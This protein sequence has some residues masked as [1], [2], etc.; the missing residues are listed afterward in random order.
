[1]TDSQILLDAVNLSKRYRASAGVEAVTV[2]RGVSLRLRA[3]ESAAIVGPSGSGKS[4]LLNI[5][6]GLDRP[7]DGKVLIDG[8]DLSQQDDGALAR[9]RNRRVGF[10]FQAH[11]LL[12]QCTVL[13]NVLVPTLVCDDRAIREKAPERAR[14]LLD[15]VGLGARL[16]HRPSQLSGGEQQRVA[17]VR[18]LI[19]CPALILAD[20]PTGALDHAAATALGE[21]MVEINREE[22]TALVVVTHS[23]ELA[24][25][26]SQVFELKDGALSTSQSK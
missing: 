3:S 24:R 6:G 13:E 21:L 20:E 5:L 7:D 8:Q 11:Y 19:N 14:K 16:G 17:V 10:I 26:M 25:R 2:L 23:S 9:I 18:A 22:K 15:H 4:T 12:P 1:M